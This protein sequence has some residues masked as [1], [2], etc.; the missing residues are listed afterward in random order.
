LYKE[1]EVAAASANRLVQEFASLGY[2]ASHARRLSMAAAAAA[3]EAEADAERER[4]R[5]EEAVQQG[6]RCTNAWNRSVE[7]ALD[8]A[9]KSA[10]LA[11]CGVW[12]GSGKEWV[13]QRNRS[14]ATLHPKTPFFIQRFGRVIAQLP[15]PPLPP[16]PPL[17][18]H[19]HTAAPP[20]AK[21]W[22]ST[23]AKHKTTDDACAPWSQVLN[24]L[25]VLDDNDVDGGGLML[26][27]VSS[28]PRDI[29]EIHSSIHSSIHGSNMT[30]VIRRMCPFLSTIFSK[31][32]TLDNLCAEPEDK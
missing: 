11:M 30:K 32:L 12:Q 26:R 21:K 5:H 10:K 25:Q 9:A 29:N 24:C 4:R 20:H 6:R 17:P 19:T 1:L 18:S 14:A 8:A 27:R 13:D 16:L 22:S 31:K 3:A 28:D 2:G 23:S 7:V 15:G